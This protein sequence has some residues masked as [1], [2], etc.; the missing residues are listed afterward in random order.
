MS[1]TQVAMNLSEVTPTHG[2][3][4]VLLGKY[5]AYVRTWRKEL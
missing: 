5:V 3:A 2:V 4:A 1:G